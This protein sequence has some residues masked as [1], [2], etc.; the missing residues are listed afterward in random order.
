VELFGLHFTAVDVAAALLT[1]A[2]SVVVAVGGAIVCADPHTRAELLRDP[3]AFWY[4]TK[5]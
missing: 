4:G 2:S 1:W 3:R 5:E